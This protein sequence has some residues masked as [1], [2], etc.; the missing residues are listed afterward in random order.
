MDGNHTNAS[1]VKELTFPATNEE[2]I[3][4]CRSKTLKVTARP[5][6]LQENFTRIMK[7]FKFKY[8]PDVYE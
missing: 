5:R 8:Q 7:I 3:N 6:P 2:T 1:F 4:H